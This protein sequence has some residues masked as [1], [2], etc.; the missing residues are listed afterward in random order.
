VQRDSLTKF[1]FES[2]PVRGEVVHLD[3]TWAAAL[4]RVE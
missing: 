4:E 2:Q 3:A 1:L